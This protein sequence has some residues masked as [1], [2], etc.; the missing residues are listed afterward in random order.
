MPGSRQRGR[1]FGAPSRA[2]H[3]AQPPEL[4][5]E[6]TDDLQQVAMLHLHLKQLGQPIVRRHGRWREV[7]VARQAVARHRRGPGQ[8]LACT[9]GADDAHREGA[10][11]LRRER[12]HLRHRVLRVDL[13]LLCLQEREWGV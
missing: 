12:M 5:A 11:R 9:S 1:Q 4:S 8:Y 13:R 3:G 2:R 7:A 10:R 6:R